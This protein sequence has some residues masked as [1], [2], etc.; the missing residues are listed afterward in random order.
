M[1][2]QYPLEDRTLDYGKRIIKMCRALP[3][4][5]VNLNLIKQVM[6]SGTSIGA[7]YREANETCTAKDFKFKVRISLK[8]SKETIYWLNLIVDSNPEYAERIKPLLSETH[9][10]VKI[11]ASILEKY[12]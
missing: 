11:F 3:K 9:E 10:L 12:K 1:N 2:Y 4:D 5:V 8:E 7:N 6:R